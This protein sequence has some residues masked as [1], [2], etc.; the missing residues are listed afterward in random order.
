MDNLKFNYYCNYYYRN[1]NNNY[2][3]KNNYANNNNYVRGQYANGSTLR[4]IQILEDYKIT[5]QSE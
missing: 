1:N 3:N 2:A 5:K 4:Q